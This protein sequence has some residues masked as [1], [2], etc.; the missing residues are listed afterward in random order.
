MKI[1]EVMSMPL[2]KVTAITPNST[3]PSKAIVNIKTADGKD[4][5]TTQGALIPGPNNTFQIKPDAATDTSNKLQAGATVTQAPQESGTMGTQPTTS[6]EMKPVG[7]D[8]SDDYINDIDDENYGRTIEEP[9][10][11]ISKETLARY[12]KGAS[13]DIGHYNWMRGTERHDDW[14]SLSD[15]EQERRLRRHDKEYNREKGIDR[16]LSRLTKEDAELESI[17]KLSGL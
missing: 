4:I 15:Y 16:A 3:D 10:D 8:P 1:R 9:L 13:D 6:E 7:G 12:V 14:D 11:E 2:G 17:K 5:Q